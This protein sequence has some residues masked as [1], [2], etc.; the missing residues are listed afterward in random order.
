MG[1]AS[2]LSTPACRRRTRS[3]GAALLHDFAGFLGHLRTPI[4]GGRRQ[5]TH[6]SSG[7]A[8][9]ATS[10]PVGPVGYVIPH[11]VASGC[12]A[13]GTPVVVDAVNPVACHGT[14]GG[15]WRALP[16]LPFAPWRCVSTTWLSTGGGWSSGSPTWRVRSCRRGS[17]CWLRTTSRGKRTGPSWICRRL[18]SSNRGGLSCQYRGSSM[19]RS[20]RRCGC[21]GD[22]LWEH[23][24]ESS[25]SSAARG[26]L[27]D[28]NPHDAELDQ[29]AGDRCR[30][31]GGVTSEA[32]AELKPLRKEN[33]ELRRANEI[34]PTA[35]GMS[36]G[37]FYY[38]WTLPDSST[39]RPPPT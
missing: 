4:L 9:G 26:A 25:C 17:R 13:V 14:G 34:L 29:A 1:E 24:G 38:A 32:S 22:R 7:F 28:I 8:P 19:R 33:A 2:G 30:R 31:V 16:E 23:P 11:H 37:H 36:A 3:A 5:R 21:T 12:L 35:S 6:L 18:P 39:S 10:T 15:R 27:F 20:A